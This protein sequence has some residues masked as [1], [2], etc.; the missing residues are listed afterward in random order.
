MRLI[1]SSTIDTQMF[2][3]ERQQMTARQTKYI[4]PLFIV[5]PAHIHPR[6]W[7]FFGQIAIAYPT[8]FNFV[9]QTNKSN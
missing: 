6:Y 7:H 2:Y 5:K 1:C 4:V 8:E 9:W 3:D